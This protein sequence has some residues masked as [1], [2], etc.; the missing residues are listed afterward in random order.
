MRPTRP[1]PVDLPPYRHR[2]MTKHADQ[3]VL[4]SID[5]ADEH[6]EDGGSKEAQGGEEKAEETTVSS[7][8][9]CG[10]GEDTLRVLL[11]RYTPTPLSR[12]L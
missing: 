1:P 2:F 11:I 7:G 3:G 5:A 9:G 6:V 10:G 4:R 8:G 12:P